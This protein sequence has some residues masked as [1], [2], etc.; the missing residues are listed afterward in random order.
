MPRLVREGAISAERIEAA[1][2]MRL[3]VCTQPHLL[4]AGHHRDAGYDPVYTGPLQNAARQE[5]MIELI[6]AI[7]DSM[8][9]YVYRFAPVEQL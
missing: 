9:P 5:S 7:G 1:A 2:G 4:V 8:G 6:F 3:A